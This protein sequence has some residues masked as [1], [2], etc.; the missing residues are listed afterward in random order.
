MPVQRVSRPD[1]HFRGFQGEVCSGSIRIGDKV[2]VLPSGQTARVSRLLRSGSD[3]DI[4]HAEDAATICLDREI[5]VSR[6]CV[7]VRDRSLIVRSKF[8]ATLLWMDDDRLSCDKPYLCRVGTQQFPVMITKIDYSIDVNT[9]R[10]IKDNAGCPIEKNTL[11]R[12]RLSADM[13]FVFDRFSSTKVMGELI[14]IDRITHMT[15]ACGVIEYSL[16]NEG[17]VKAQDYSLTRKERE[18]KNGHKAVTI[19]FTGL[20]GSGKSTLANE[21][22][23][24]LFAAGFHTMVLDGD[25]VR[26]GLNKDLGFSASDR[27]ENIRRIA[28]TAKLMND[29]GL[30]VLAAFISPYDEDRRMAREIIGDSYFEVYVSTDISVCESRDVKGLYQKARR[31][32]IKDFTGVSGKYEVPASPDITID[33]AGKTA[34]EC[35]GLIMK[36]LLNR[37]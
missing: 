35:A 27:K 9:G 15:S 11:V 6:G 36:E 18:Q 20:S 31:G 8:A 30:I 25:N 3:C 10:H 5:D 24:N 19:W 28:E 12:C 21:L 16:G 32:E 23:K 37:V 26:L 2:K 29:A 22:E 14:L 1:F 34:A 33:T 17:T 7:F 4:V 13:P